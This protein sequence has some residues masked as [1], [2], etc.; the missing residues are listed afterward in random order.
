M[1]PLHHT[2]TQDTRAA[3][4]RPPPLDARFRRALPHGLGFPLNSS[5]ISPAFD[6]IVD[7]DVDVNGDGDVNGDSVA[8]AVNDR[9][10]VNVNV[11]VNEDENDNDHEVGGAESSRIPDGVNG[12]PE[13]RRRG[14]PERM[15]R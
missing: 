14:P 9:D 13:V 7:V 3:L 6:R 8:V 2:P 12:K 10:N 1:A 5:G 11:N 15:R 4:Q